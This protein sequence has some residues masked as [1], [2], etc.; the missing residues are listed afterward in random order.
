M[1]KRSIAQI[2]SWMSK[3]QDEHDACKPS[4]DTSSA[5][6]GNSWLPTRFLHL[7][8]SNLQPIVALRHAKSQTPSSS[9]KYATLSHCWGKI[10]PVRLLQD[11]LEAFQRNIDFTSLP[12]TFQH[13]ILLCLKLGICYLWI[14][15]LCIIQDSK[16]DWLAESITMGKVYSQSFLNIAGTSSKDGMGGLFKNGRVIAAPVILP[17]WTGVLQ[18]RFYV[19]DY[20]VWGRR[21]DGAVLN[22]RAWVLQERL[23]APRTVHF[24]SDQVWWTCINASHCNE[25]W[26]NGC[27]PPTWSSISLNVLNRPGRDIRTTEWTGSWMSLVQVYSRTNLT[28][29]S[30]KLIALSGIAEAV[31]EAHKTDDMAP[32]DYL[33]GIWRAHAVPMLCWQAP[34]PSSRPHIVNAPTASHPQMARFKKT[35]QSLLHKTK[36]DVPE[37]YRAP[38]WSWASVDGRVGFPFNSR[39]APKTEAF[40]A[41]YV[42]A[43]TD[44]INGPFGPVSGGWIK[45]QGPLLPL[46]VTS[47]APGQR[48]SEGWT[49]SDAGLEQMR[50]GFFEL[51]DDERSYE[52]MSDPSDYFYACLVFKESENAVKVE[53]TAWGLLLKRDI[54]EKTSFV[55]VGWLRTE[56]RVSVQ[57]VLE[58]FRTSYIIR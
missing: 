27:P 53:S 54:R 58:S 16:D 18:G 1:F 39:N 4:T 50:A 42:D 37:D 49:L 51:M 24:A 31:Y 30:D 22:S 43:K 47:S 45:L 33:A 20:S 56:F 3:C 21:I 44:T 41:S 11:S 48:R 23:L 46:E 35:V 52:R 7:S 14:D 13:A 10:Q 19:A 2:S 28:K 6:M 29:G 57:H 8:E 36:A 34:T 5:V 9:T 17:T 26:P 38:S 12:W 15:S 55:R 32:E 40:V 25:Q